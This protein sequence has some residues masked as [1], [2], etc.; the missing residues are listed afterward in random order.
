MEKEVVKILDAGIIH[1]ITDNEWVS[2]F[3]LVPQKYGM[4]AIRNECDKLISNGAIIGWRM[5]INYK[6][7]NQAT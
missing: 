1:S 4:I 3:Q 2:P 6:K 7:S 5:S